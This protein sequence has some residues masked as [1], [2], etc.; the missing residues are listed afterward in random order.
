[1]EKKVTQCAHCDSVS[2][3][4]TLHAACTGSQPGAYCAPV[5]AR[6][7]TVALYTCYS[8]ILHS[9]PNLSLFR[10]SSQANNCINT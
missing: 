10:G 4:S 3:Q 5:V 2:G 6:G 7:C 8:M 1:M 9:P